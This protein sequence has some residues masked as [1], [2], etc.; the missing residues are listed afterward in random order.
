[1][2]LEKLFYFSL[3]RVLEVSQK[4]FEVGVMRLRVGHQV[5]IAWSILFSRDYTAANL[6]VTVLVLILKEEVGRERPQSVE[7]TLFWCHCSPFLVCWGAD[8]MKC[9]VRRP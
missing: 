1:M 9:E 2:C 8:R 3:N 4:R 7:T 5:L 6:V